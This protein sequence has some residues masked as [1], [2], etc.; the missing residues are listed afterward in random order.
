M[1]RLGQHVAR[2]A[3]LDHPAAAEDR[4]PV[5][6][7]VGVERV[8]RHDDRRAVG[9][10]LGQ[11]PAELA[12]HAH[13]ERGERLVQQDQVGLGGEGACDGDALRLPA[14]EL[15]RPAFGQRADAGA[16]QPLVGLRARLRPGG[17]RRPRGE[18]D[19][20]A[21]GQVREEQGVL[22]EQ[23]DPAAV[24]R[25]PGSREVEQRLVRERGASRVRPDQA[26]QHP[27]HR[28]LARA[29]RP[30]QGQR[31]ARAEPQLHL[32]VALGDRRREVEAHEAAPGTGR[33]LRRSGS[34]A[35][36]ATATTAMATAISTSDSATAV[37]GSVSR[38][39]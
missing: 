7:Q 2:R 27:E 5:G 37:S 34:P 10:H 12:R 13:V 4:D 22:G 33:G 21:H 15:V 38:C 28:G 3:L 11:H 30:E 20:P 31:L 19:V 16:L 8:V 1:P 17:T 29:V 36:W 18:L 26:R 23:C 25:Q 9:E 6:E 32:D 24:R 14:G 39:R 35:P